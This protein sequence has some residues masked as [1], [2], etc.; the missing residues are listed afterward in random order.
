MLKNYKISKLKFF[1]GLNVK[2]RM[3]LNGYCRFFVRKI[4]RSIYL[5]FIS[6]NHWPAAWPNGYGV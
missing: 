2:K 6:T 4:L 1:S 5:F 3:R